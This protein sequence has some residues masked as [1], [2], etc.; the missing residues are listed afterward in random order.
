L[1][2]K[3][4]RGALVE[5]KYRSTLIPEDLLKISQEIDD[6]WGNTYLFVA[7][8]CNEC[9]VTLRFRYNKVNYGNE[10]IGRFKQRRAYY[11]RFIF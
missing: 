6:Q 7:S 10:K 11:G 8:K 1:V 9:H 2:K 4:E 3:E 5:V